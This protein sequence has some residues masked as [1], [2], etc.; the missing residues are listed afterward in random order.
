[1]AIIRRV[2]QLSEMREEVSDLKA[3]ESAASADFDLLAQ[4][5]IAGTENPYVINGFT[6]NFA[7]N[8]IGGASTNL[9]LVVANGAL[10]ATTASQ[11]GTF[12]LVAPGTPNLV[13]NAATSS[14]VYGSFVP[15]SFNYVGIDYYRFQDPTT[16]TQRYIWNPT[17]QDETQ[18]IA[19]A[20]IV[21]NYEVV[22]SSSIWAANI[23]PIA[24]VETNSSNN[25]VSVTDARPLLFRLG[26]GGAAPNPYYVYPFP[27]GTNENSVTSTSNSTNPFYGGDKAITDLKDWMNAV[28]T[29]LLD[30]G[31][32]PYWYSYASSYPSGSIPQL[33]EDATNTILTGNGSI[34]HGVVPDAF[35]CSNYDRQYHSWQQ[36]NHGVGFYH[37][38]RFGSIY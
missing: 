18:I 34:S 9:Q 23:L 33:R 12:F 19:P 30:I 11:S 22:I 35:S 25:V 38:N 28:M 20:A 36:S 8:P 2:N 5:F 15:S 4:S 3:I 14:N 32:G 29:L 24:I 27:Q 13:L 37:W 7:S 1:M 31:G 21:L 26:S 16:D 17:A 6:I 10:L